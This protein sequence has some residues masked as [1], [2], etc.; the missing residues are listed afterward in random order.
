MVLLSENSPG[1]PDL[2]SENA[3]A[4]VDR[5]VSGIPKPCVELG[6]ARIQHQGDGLAC[7]PPV[8]P[9]P[10]PLALG[11]AAASV[12]RA[13][14]SKSRVATRSAVGPNLCNKKSLL[15]GVSKFV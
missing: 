12:S 6:V 11:R 5:E 13:D 14:R 4:P 9:V 1:K 7:E 10:I 2:T 15:N 3:K 8:S